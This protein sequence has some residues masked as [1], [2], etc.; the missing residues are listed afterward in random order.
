M[1]AETPCGGVS[2]DDM[3]RRVKEETSEPPPAGDVALDGEPPPAEDTEARETVVLPAEDAALAPEETPVQLALGDLHEETRLAHDLFRDGHRQEAVRKAAQRFLNRLSERAEHPK[4]QGTALVNL[5]FSEDAPL[6]AFTARATRAER[7]EHNGYRFLG[8][9][10]TLAIR[11]VMT[12]TDDRGLT[13]AEAFEWLAF[14]SAM[15][16]RLDNAQQVP[17]ESGVDPETTEAS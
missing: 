9:G 11:N 2:F 7:D 14:I 16:R 5:A 13:P 6:L 4:K 8:A 10:L 12:H 1:T 17:P 3:L 15:H